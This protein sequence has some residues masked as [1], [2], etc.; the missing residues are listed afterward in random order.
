MKIKDLSI[1]LRPRE[2]LIKYGA[3]NLASEELIAIIIGSG[4]KGKSALELANEIL[5]K[6]NLREFSELSYENLIKIKGISI[7]KATSILAAF[8]IAKRSLSFEMEASVLNSASD[9]YSYIAPYLKNKFR[10][11][12]YAIYLDTKASIIK[13]VLI[14]D[15]EVSFVN[16]SIRKII[17]IAL[18]L[19]AYGLILV[20]NHPSGE[21]KPSKSDI[22][23]TK[24]L[25]SSTKLFDI[26]FIDHIIIGSNKYYS[27]LENDSSCFDKSIDFYEGDFN[28]KNNF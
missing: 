28:E 11:C 25:S 3:Q 21:I 24:M 1:N 2:K 23:T 20:H 18:E 17:K 19:E 4:I 16:I 26:A 5:Q 14:N 22:I 7:S 9:V 12:A 6:Y 27:F 8:E 13:K 10:E 15:G